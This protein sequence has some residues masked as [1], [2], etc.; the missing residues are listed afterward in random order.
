MNHYIPKFVHT[1]RVTRLTR[2]QLCQCGFY[3]YQWLS[4][5]QMGLQPTGLPYLVND[6]KKILYERLNIY[7]HCIAH[8]R[9]FRV[10]WNCGAHSMENSFKVPKFY[11][12]SKRLQV[13]SAWS[14][15]AQRSFGLLVLASENSKW[16]LRRAR[17]FIEAFWTFSQNWDTWSQR[18]ARM[19]IQKK[20][21]IMNI[22]TKNY[23][24]SQH[25][26]QGPLIFMI[27]IL[28]E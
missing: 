8:S 4:K 23:N 7:T 15:I 21:W 14:K 18:A 5:H 27:F 10:S 6:F 26:P 25:G 24:K 2:C 19:Q 20:A 12:K 22:Y 3:Q 16:S 28:P 11:L 9:C 17:S 1:T 13:F